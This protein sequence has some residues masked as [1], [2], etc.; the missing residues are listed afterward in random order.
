MNREELKKIIVFL[1]C[2]VYPTLISI[3]AFIGAGFLILAGDGVRLALGTLL[4]LIGMIIIS[5]VFGYNIIINESY[6]TWFIIW[7]LLQIQFVIIFTLLDFIQNEI[8]NVV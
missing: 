3:V 4:L 6:E 5:S 2:I 8:N 1:C 7:I